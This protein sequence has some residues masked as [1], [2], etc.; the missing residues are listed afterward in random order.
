MKQRPK[1]DCGLEAFFQVMSSNEKD[2]VNLIS[3]SVGQEINITYH[4][5]EI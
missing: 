3:V 5:R 2:Q 1:Y 4:K